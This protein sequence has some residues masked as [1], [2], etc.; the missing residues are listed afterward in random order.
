MVGSLWVNTSCQQR[1]DNAF[2]LILNGL[3]AD[4]EKVFVDLTFWHML[5]LLVVDANNRAGPI[6]FYV[7]CGLEHSFS[8]EEQEKEGYPERL[9]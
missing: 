6:R 2:L 1:K 7:H 4:V 8:T 3:P 5:P 9:G